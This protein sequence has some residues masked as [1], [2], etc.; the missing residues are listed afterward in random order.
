MNASP[1]LVVTNGDLTLQNANDA[2]IKICGG[3]CTM[4]FAQEKPI[5]AQYNINMNTTTPTAG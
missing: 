3:N 2:E 1:P 4:L 5:L